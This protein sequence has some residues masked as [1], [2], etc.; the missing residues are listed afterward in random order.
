[1][2]PELSRMESPFLSIKYLAPVTTVTTLFRLSIF[3]VGS[4]ASG[5]GVASMV[6]QQASAV[7]IVGSGD[8]PMVPASPGGGI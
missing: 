6:I 7:G 4:G 5:M 3:P 8:G 2:P 1:M